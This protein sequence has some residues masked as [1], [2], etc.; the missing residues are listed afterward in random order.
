VTLSDLA[1]VAVL[2]LVL[3][4]FLRTCCVSSSPSE[5][6][7][8]SQ[9]DGTGTPDRPGARRPEGGVVSYSIGSGC[10]KQCGSRA[11]GPWLTLT[12]VTYPQNPAWGMET[13]DA[14]W[15][16]SPVCLTTYVT[17]KREVPS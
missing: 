1:T 13:L 12:V 3:V 6:T 2:V 16:C 8:G 5:G 4:I 17:P 15:F 14:G 9:G 7:A 11:G 10:C